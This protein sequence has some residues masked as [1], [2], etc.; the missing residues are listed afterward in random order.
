MD[1]VM[2]DGKEFEIEHRIEDYGKEILLL[3]RSNKET[4]PAHP[5]QDIRDYCREHRVWAAKDKNPWTGNNGWWGWTARPETKNNPTPDT[6]N[7]NFGTVLTL[8]DNLTFP[9]CP[10]NKSLIAPDGSMPLMEPK[11]KQ[12]SHGWIVGRFY[13]DKTKY[14]P[15]ECLELTPDGRAYMSPFPNNTAHR[16]SPYPWDPAAWTLIADKKASN[17]TLPSRGDPI[18]VW[19][20]DHD[21][22][23]PAPVVYF[24]SKKRK[25]SCITFAQGVYG[26][27]GQ[28]WD[29]YRPFDPALVGVP[30]KDW[31][32]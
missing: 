15:R 3:R 9:D 30:R 22:R 1:K 5:K 17:P 12:P 25:D 32:V 29:H 28:I 6:W 20:D 14:S 11:A 19:N 10:W 8:P 7:L 24:Y 16:Y 26:T 2:I 13:N 4:K 31:P 23:C 18:F 21:S 27:S